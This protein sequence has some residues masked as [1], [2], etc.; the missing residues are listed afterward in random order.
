MSDMIKI[1]KKII[2]LVC[3][4][5]LFYSACF[6]AIISW[7]GKGF[8]KS[9]NSAIQRKYDNLISTN[10]PK[11]IIL[12]GSSAA[13]G[14]NVKRLEEASGYKIV[15]MGLHAGF[16]G[17]FNMEIGKQNINKGDIVLLALEYG[18]YAENYF[19]DIS[20]DLV[21]CGL[22][23]RL[24][25]YSIIPLNKLDGILGYLWTY[26]DK[27]IESIRSHSYGI[28]E[29][30]VY[31]ID[32]FDEKGDMIFDRPT[33]ILTD[34]YYN[35]QTSLYGQEDLS[36]VA[37]SEKSKAYL[38]EYKL[39]VESK[40]AKIYFV[41]VPLLDEAKVSSDESFQSLANSVNKEIGIKYVSNP[42]DYLFPSELMYD[43]I[44]HCNDKG[45]NKRTDILI[46]DLT[47]TKII[48]KVGVK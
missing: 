14:F 31:S 1:V 26:A 29:N 17:L 43:T 16:G 13:F 21:M 11:I 41:G 8:N 4:W 35:K 42:L 5:F 30:S 48:E 7:S 46:S 47:S 23:N 33:N 12:G 28:V 24:D 36:N 2:L 37:I 39:F 6:M 9:Y 10:D 40:G 3:V 27:K 18:W 15:N 34:E 32:S 38:K 45:A 22:D 44:Y 19:Q 25:M 20:V